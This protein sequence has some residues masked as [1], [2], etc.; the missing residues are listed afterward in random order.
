MTVRPIA[1][2]LS[3]L[4]LLACADPPT[5]VL[6]EETA[7]ETAERQPPVA[8][9]SEGTPEGPPRS[10]ENDSDAATSDAAPPFEDGGSDD[11]AKGKGKRKD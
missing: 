2:A 8:P 4:S 3:F 5:F 11:G 9:A 6:S 7:T 1:L 10:S